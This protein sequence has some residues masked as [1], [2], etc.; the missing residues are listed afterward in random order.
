MDPVILALTSFVI[1]FLAVRLYQ[2]I[3]VY[4]LRWKVNKLER[5]IQQL[6]NRINKT[7]RLW[8]I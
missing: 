1:L 3:R 2:H 5:E 8:H 4:Y 7:R 6:R